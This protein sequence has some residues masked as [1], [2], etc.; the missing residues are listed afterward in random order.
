MLAKKLGVYYHDGLQVTFNTEDEL[1][2]AKERII[3]FYT[4]S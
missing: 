1:T 2:L 3:N 4:S